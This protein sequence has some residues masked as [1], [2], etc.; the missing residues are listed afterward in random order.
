MYLG[1]FI[2]GCKYF[3]IF[4]IESVVSI[5]SL[6]ICVFLWPF[7]LIQYSG[8]ES[9][10]FLRLKYKRSSS[11]HL[12]WWNAYG[13]LLHKNSNN[14]KAAIIWGIPKYIEDVCSHSSRQP[15][16]SLNPG[17]ISDPPT[18]RRK[19]KPADGSIH[20]PFK[21]LLAIWFSHL[22]LRVPWNNEKPSPL[23]L[24]KIL[25]QLVMPQ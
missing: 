22:R 7:Q 20:Q 11:F 23:R 13:K 25:D 6:W 3:E 4:P 12:I 5:P 18:E 2:T 1:G 15:W 14:H 17:A 21:T 24:I 10:W 9:M 16:L 19:R 8:S